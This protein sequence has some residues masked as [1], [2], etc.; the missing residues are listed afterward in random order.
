[1][2]PI[3]QKCRFS[4]KEFIITDRDQE[5]YARL[6]VPL[7]TLCP[8]ERHRRRLAYRNERTLYYRKCDVTGKIMM[9]I[10]HQ[11]RPFPV[12][13][14]D[15]WWSDNWDA[16]DYGRDFDFS[17]PFFEQFY[18]L[19][20][21]VPHCNLNVVKPTL[22]NSDYCNQTGYIK[23]CYLIFDSRFSEKCMYSKSLEKCYE[24]LDCYKVFESELCYE[25]DFCTNCYACTYLFNSQNC[26]DCHYSAN[27]IG[28]K[29]CFGCTDLRNKEYYFL[30]Q[31]CESKEAW[32]IKVRDILHKLSRD[33]LLQYFLD[34]KEKQPA[35]YM[36]EL[37]TENC[38]G[39]FLIGCKDCVECYDSEDLE[40]CSFCF[41]IKR[42]PD[43]SPS[44][45]NYDISHFGGT[46]TE[47]YEG[48][49]IGNHGT[50][51]CLF[52]ES[53]WSSSDVYYSRLCN[54]NCNNLFGCVCL[55]NAKYCIFN[56]QYSKEEYEKLVPR[57]IEHMKRTPYPEAPQG[58]VEWGEF[59]P[60]KYSPF[61]YNETL[62]QEQFPITKEDALTHNWKW[63]DEEIE[64]A[65]KKEGEDIRTCK[66]TGKPFRITKQELEFYK[67]MNLPLPEK[68]FEARHMDR[69]RRRN[70]RQLH[71]R[72][73]DK[74]GVE[75]TTTYSPDRR[76]GGTGKPQAIY[77]RKC[78][79][80]SA[81][82]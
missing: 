51:R 37:N 82:N 56:K 76:L 5:F 80:N 50:N 18:E 36:V 21:S 15:Y 52:T 67:K 3:T 73:C 58:G 20:N 43:H 32:E 66:E 23:D 40:K 65:S 11:G 57:I 39:D 64:E 34:F 24:C 35:K 31:K 27:L 14:N 78:Y 77:C 33:K 1:M 81:V 74:C 53:V 16:K 19:Q 79:L 26:S 10:H 29:N 38:T 17:R 7:P 9:S 46:L 22:E 70:P 45:M 25:C 42:T 6:N 12:Y 61:G 62:A 47:C 60:I 59:F 30:N 28:C 71:E 69:V 55:R 48:C 63:K 54:T 8:A 41:D 72:N 44:F 75:I 4:G 13:E 49:S 2:P 68:C